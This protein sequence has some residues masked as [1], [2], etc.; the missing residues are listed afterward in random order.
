MSL[1][2]FQSSADKSLAL[3]ARHPRRW[4]P[5][6]FLVALGFRSR[7]AN[8]IMEPPGRLRYRPQHEHRRL[9]HRDFACVNLHRMPPLSPLYR[10][11][12]GG[13]SH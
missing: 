7:S 9:L 3:V 2:P 6:G 13:P 5:A 11:R 12:S 8:R 1:L 10:W 4:N